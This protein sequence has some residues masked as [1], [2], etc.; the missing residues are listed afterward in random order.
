MFTL[1]KTYKNSLDSTAIS[2]I[3]SKEYNNLDSL[4]GVNYIK[5]RE[6]IITDSNN[7]NTPV[8]INAS[9]ISGVTLPT[10]DNTKLPLDGGSMKGQ[11][12]F[13]G[14][15][16]LNSADPTSSKSLATKQYVDTAINS[17]SGGGGGSG[18]SSLTI[19]HITSNATLESFT[20]NYI[21]ATANLDL[22][23]PAAPKHNDYLE[24]VDANHCFKLFIIT[25]NR[26]NSDHYINGKKSSDLELFNTNCI[27][28]FLYNDKGAEK[29]WI[30][31][32]SSNVDDNYNVYIDANTNPAT[33]P[34]GNIIDLK[35]GYNYYINSVGMR[36][37]LRLPLIMEI[38]INYLNYINI[39]DTNSSF[40][41]SPCV[42][43]AAKD[44][45][46][47]KPGDDKNFYSEYTLSTN[48]QAVKMLMINNNSWQIENDVSL[49]FNYL[50]KSGGNMSGDIDMRDNSIVKINR[51]NR[52]LNVITSTLEDETIVLTKNS[53]E[54]IHIQDIN[55]RLRIYLP[56]TKTLT[57]GHTF[58]ITTSDL[59]KFPK[60]IMIFPYNAA[61]VDTITATNKTSSETVDNI[62]EYLGSGEESKLRYSGEIKPN[63]PKYNWYN[64]KAK[65]SDSPAEFNYF[66]DQNTNLVAGYKYHVDTT[67][68]SIDCILPDT[69]VNGATVTIVDLKN[70]FKVNPLQ[71]IC[72]PDT[73]I[74]EINKNNYVADNCGNV[75]EVIY[76]S[77][78]AMW[79]VTNTEMKGASYSA[80]GETGLVPAPN[81][82]A[83]NAVLTGASKW[84]NIP[85]TE[86]KEI[87]FGDVVAV[88]YSTHYG[89]DTTNGV[90]SIT[91]PATNGVPDSASI[92]FTDISGKFDTNA[93][94]VSTAAGGADSIINSDNAATLNSFTFNAKNTLAIF[95]K[96]K[97]LWYLSLLTSNYDKLLPKAGGIMSGVID[98]SQNKVIN[99]DDPTNTADAATKN[100][101]DTEL[102]AVNSAKLSVNGTNKMIADLDVGD[103]KLINVKDPTAAT[104]AATKKYVDTS[105]ALKLNTDGANKMLS[106]L[107]FNANKG[108]N[109]LDPTATT[110][111]ANKKYVDDNLTALSEKKLN[112]DG[113]NKMTSDLDLG[114]FKAINLA[115]PVNIQDATTKKYVDDNLTALSE[116]KLNIDGTNKM[117]SDLNLNGFNITQL[118]EPTISTDAA[119][120]NY[121]DFNLTNIADN[122]LNLDGSNKMA[123][124]LD[125]NNYKI[126]KLA[127]PIDITDA[128]NK[129]YVDINLITAT[130]KK[131]NLD[132][133]NEMKS[134]LNLDGF[135]IIN[136]ADPVVATDVATKNYTDNN[137]EI[138][139]AAKINLDGTN[140][141]TGNLDLN[142]HTCINL[143]DPINNADAAT[144]K[145]VDISLSALDDI[146]LDLDG[147]N[148]MLGNLNFNGYTGVNLIDP[149]NSSDIAT[150][151]YTDTSLTALA[152]AKLNIDGTNKMTGNLDFNQ[153]KGIN[154][155][156]PTNLTDAVTKNYVDIS[157]AD[158]NSSSDTRLNLDGTS[159]MTGDLDFNGNKGINL[160]DPTDLTDAANKKYVDTKFTN[161]S[162][163]DSK[164]NLD[165][166]SKMTGDLDFNGNKGINLSDPTDLTDAA[167][168]KY[169]D[170][171]F[172]NLS[173][174]DSKLNLDGTSKM[175]GNLDFNSNKGINLSDP[176]DLTDA[177]NKKYVDTK[178]NLDGT[179][180][181][182]GNLDFNSNK[183]I[184]LSDPTDLTDAA[185]KKYVDTKFTNLSSSDSKLNLDGTSKMTGNLD[186]NSNKGINLSDPTDLTDAANKKYVDTKLNLDGT[187]KMTGNLD[188]NSN[189]GINLSDPTDLTDAANKKYV[190]TKFTNLS[191][192]DSKL[193]LDGTSKMTGNLDF[194][195]NKGINLS[196]PTDLTDAAN[197]KYVDTKL[198][199]D[200]TDKMTGNLDFNSNKG[201]NLSDPTD[202]TDAANK[203]YVDT[204][205]NLDGTDKMTGN[206]DFNSNKGINLSDPTDLKDAANK[207]YVDTKFTALDEAKLNL[208]G[209]SKMTGNLDFNLNKGI[210]LS[211]PTDIKD[212]SNK[213][214][215]DTTFAVLSNNSSKKRV[216]YIPKRTYSGYCF[217]CIT[218]DDDIMTHG[219]FAVNIYMNS[220][221]AD[222][223][224]IPCYHTLNGVK[225]GLWAGICQS[226]TSLYCWTTT[227]EI[228]CGGVNG[229]G[230]LA[231]GDTTLRTVLTKCN[232]FSW[233]STNTV[234]D[235]II[236][237][238]AYVN[239]TVYVLNNLGEVWGA[240]LN[241][242]GGLATKDTVDR[243]VW[244]KLTGFTGKAVK[245]AATN[246]SVAQAIYIITDAATSNLWVGGANASGN[247]G[248]G[249]TLT[250]LE[251][252]NIN[253][254][255]KDIMVYG[256]GAVL[257]MGSSILTKDGKIK[258]C[259]ENFTG[260]LGIGITSTTTNVYTQEALLK[261]NWVSMGGNLDAVNGYRWAIDS[262]GGFYRWGYNLNYCLGGG[263]ALG[264][265]N[266]PTP[267]MLTDLP[268]GTATIVKVESGFAN[269]A[270]MT[271]VLTSDGNL[272]HCGRSTNYEKG[273]YDTTVN[274]TFKLIPRPA[275][276]V[277]WAD[278]I[279]VG[280]TNVTHIHAVTEYGDLYNWGYK[281]SGCCVGHAS[282]SSIFK[283]SL[284]TL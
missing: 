176:T 66:I 16:A 181:M 132:G 21:S 76:D 36:P 99:L 102:A 94:T 78:T 63:N 206:L 109:L 222:I 270:T 137:L 116:K 120:K 251:L 140:K 173:S 73:S 180:K 98:M 83:Y 20:D 184:N 43:V 226:Y 198:N 277:K 146:K 25:V 174:S 191:S 117:T 31:T 84:S 44:D 236:S 91:L 128:A 10:D 263:A 80:A 225:T 22:L 24:I 210:N 15:E 19:K 177:A 139:N 228:W 194:N 133:S 212:A 165:G 130:E 39:I 55:D 11:I 172:T 267:V 275:T 47:Y 111:A 96:V 167:N 28:K 105:D 92:Q 79:V 188:F 201:I 185:N 95:T 12:D 32:L 155:A 62:L 207:K 56:D 112:I 65:V 70:T 129:K 17:V 161:L 281:T 189:K 209:T 160:S 135:K 61:V 175:T 179:D 231:L 110:D 5:A 49:T 1:S 149:I 97:T 265:S 34:E 86:Y 26:S 195:S 153:N 229:A 158:L 148:K 8:K 249:T 124:D 253:E 235:L 239:Q 60:I 134:N 245:I 69:P 107:N 256:V 115:N 90:I 72:A 214:Y 23:L 232:S 157:I 81:A 266:K 123:S 166:T 14:Y 208:D 114:G 67:N 197:K 264:T 42:L 104:D 215:V 183:G 234:V 254:S 100:Y 68:G 211:D 162:S 283:P 48:N 187:D 271:I 218:N 38:S 163:S 125:M 273:S 170:T 30:Y 269:E 205:L 58:T 246:N 3:A 150:K 35:R 190:D 274:S 7:N 216:K 200:G 144:K 238:S 131:L 2:V 237:G 4:V 145:Y 147:T 255:V 9:G 41:E 121:V 193:N 88:E 154:L 52:N 224:H 227:G 13:G 87:K 196:D 57:I 192:S 284:V 278:V 101:V 247:L 260:Q 217:G 50:L 54:L 6:L 108:I 282:S 219:N 33:T 127:D 122:K 243:Y 85:I 118:A 171:K 59:I 213:N 136:T 280:D 51:L 159:K 77:T 233:P 168:K 103:F 71:L 74:A 268:W 220:T 178:L 258:S 276:G 151:N 152:A 53:V 29:N 156:D 143:V 242:T 241:N 186:F 106:S 27:H 89:V 40:K 164:L 221:I 262:A 230:S 64:N 203:K 82:A 257:S 75:F 138:L 204:K 240:G 272:W 202:L 126:V 169:V 248:N 252:V 199:L 113:T 261:N 45:Y 141:L 119:T 18:G 279:V 46:I 93:F 259:G 244:T 142:G 250:K 182:T 37:L 223:A